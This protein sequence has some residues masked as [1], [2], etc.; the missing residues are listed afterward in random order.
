M[1]GQPAPHFD[2]EKLEVYKKAMDL[3]EEVFTVCKDF[4]PRLKNSIVDRLQKAVLAVS[5]NIA[6]GC[7][8]KSR[9]DKIKYF[10][11]ALDSAQECIPCIALAHSQNQ[12]DKA[13]NEHLRDS[14]TVVCHMLGELIQNV[15]NEELSRA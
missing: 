10:S 2:F 9:R 6:E 8:K 7:G 12:I 14:C 15:E 3:A 5:T 1:Q 13:K 11:Y 4:E